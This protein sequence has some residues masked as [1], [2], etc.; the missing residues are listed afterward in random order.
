MIFV[1]EYLTN[2][3]ALL[4]K[5]ILLYVALL[6]GLNKESTYD[7]VNSRFERSHV[8]ESTSIDSAEVECWRTSALVSLSLKYRTRK[9]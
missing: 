3:A 5:I 1:R 4:T 6:F 2:D 7:C 8:W 9:I